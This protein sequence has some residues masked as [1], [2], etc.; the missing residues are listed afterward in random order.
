LQ[1][2][3]QTTDCTVL[4]SRKDFQAYET[5]EA[6]VKRETGWRRRVKQIYNKGRS[7]FESDEAYDDYLE[8]IEDKVFRLQSKETSKE[9]YE[10][11]RTQI[12][13]DERALQQQN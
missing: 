12:R 11:L 10:K 7:D 6:F 1:Q 2:K 3:C 4:L 5:L 8:E 9:D 13:A